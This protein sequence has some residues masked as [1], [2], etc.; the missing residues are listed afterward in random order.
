LNSRKRALHYQIVFLITDQMPLAIDSI[1]QLLSLTGHSVFSL[2]DN[3]LARGEW[4]D[5]GI[6]LLQ[7]GITRDAVDICARLLSHK[8]ASASISAWALDVVQPTLQSEVE[9]M[10][11]TG[12]D[13]RNNIAASPSLSSGASSSWASINDPESVFGKVQGTCSSFIVGLATNIDF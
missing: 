10:Y 2:I 5:E 7:E 11:R 3:I 1:L 8:P 4:E 13:K 9:E 6:K 12:R